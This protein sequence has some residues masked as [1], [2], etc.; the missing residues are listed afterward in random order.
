MSGVRDRVFGQAPIGRNSDPLDLESSE[1]PMIGD[2]LTSQPMWIVMASSESTASDHLADLVRLQAERARASGHKPGEMV[3][4]VEAIVIRRNSETG[5]KHYGLLKWGLIPNHAPN[6]SRPHL[7][8]RAETVAELRPFAQSFRQRRCVIT[9]DFFKQ[10]RTI[11]QPKGKLFAIGMA[12][13]SDL[14]I[15][16][17][18]DAWNIRGTDTWIRTFA[19]ITVPANELVGEIHDRMPAILTKDQLPFWFGDVEMPLPEVQDLLRPFPSRG[20]IRWPAESKRPPMVVEEQQPDSEPDLFT[21]R[22]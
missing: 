20:M 19:T 21:P 10:R 3:E 14:L 8:A 7:H 6:M 17:I 18:W 13:Q 2:N 11:G 16:G 9:V 12:D 4:G 22:S 1:G 5:R 15:A